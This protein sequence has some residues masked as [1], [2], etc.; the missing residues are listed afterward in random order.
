MAMYND[1]PDQRYR[2]INLV[3]DAFLVGAGRGSALLFIRG[4]RSSSDASLPPSVLPARTRLACPWPYSAPSTDREMRMKAGLPALVP[5]GVLSIIT[6]MPSGSWG[7][8]QRRLRGVEV[9]MFFF[10][11]RFAI[12]P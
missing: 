4:F 2:F 7:S 11:L 3:G 6:P 9:K 5:S 1:I 8:S 12:V 10:F